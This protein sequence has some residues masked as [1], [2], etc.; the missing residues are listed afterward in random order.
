MNILCLLIC[1]WQLYAYGAVSADVYDW[2]QVGND[3]DG[4]EANSH[5]GEVAINSDGTIVALATRYF[6]DEATQTQTNLR[7]GHIRVF[8]LGD[9]NVWTELGADPGSGDYRG[10][11]GKTAADYVGNKFTAMSA[12]GHTIATKFGQFV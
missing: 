12:S 3:I 9:G 8:E 10:I 6:R 5:A 11:M 4:K 2:T 1:D 7:V